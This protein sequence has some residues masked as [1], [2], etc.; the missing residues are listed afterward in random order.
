MLEI[1]IIGLGLIG[2][3]I[4]KALKKNNVCKTIIAYDLNTDN[5]IIAQKEGI[6]DKRVNQINNEFK[7]C[8][9]I[10]VCTPIEYIYEIIEQL[11]AIVKEGCIITDVGS[12][13]SKLENKIFNSIKGVRFVGGHPMTGLEKSGYTYSSEILLENAYYLLTK[14]KF[15]SDNDLNIIKNIIRKI[16]AIPII[17]DSIEH[18]YATANISHIPHIIATT[19]VN[20]VKNNDTKEK[21]LHK[22]AAGGFRDIT[23]IASSSP[24]IWEDICISNSE[25]IINNL[26]SIK[27]E[28]D[29]ILNAIKNSDRKQIN[30]YFSSS[31]EYRDS[32]EIRNT[33]LIEQIYDF[34][35]SIEDKPGMI[36]K[37]AT[38]LS[39]NKINIKNIGIVNNREAYEGALRIEFYNERSKEKAYMT[40]KDLGYIVYLKD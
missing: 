27:R 21:H 26:E 23:R 14:N 25:Q 8:D 15:T 16:K 30:L 11:N 20:M 10:F 35:I 39:N 28:I 3:S 4:A 32:F 40:L 17:I 2:G 31:K 7:N 38:I 36:A 37:I 18:D 12:T 33:G 34:S 5:L 1:G 6:V 29:K 13:K 24:K 22:L 19:L 9:V